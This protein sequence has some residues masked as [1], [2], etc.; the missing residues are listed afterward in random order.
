[1]VFQKRD[2]KLPAL[3]SLADA[4]NTLPE[5]ERD[6]VV[7]RYHDGLTMMQIGRVMGIGEEKAEGLVYDAVRKL[8]ERIENMTSYDFEKA[9]KKLVISRA[10]VLYG[11]YYTIDQIN[12]VWFAHVLGY[13]KAILIDSGDNQRIYEVTYNMGKDEF[14]VDT[15]EKRDNM[16]ASA[17]IFANEDDYLTHS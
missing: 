7:L 15:Y 9:A 12:M 16:K 14:Y 3:Q 1:M 17:V 2:E 10:A 6:V 13:K 4:L 5:Q 8:W 11:E